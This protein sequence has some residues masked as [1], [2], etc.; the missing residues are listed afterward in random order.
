MEGL[1]PLQPPE[2][3]DIVPVFQYYLRSPFC[4]PMKVVLDGGI[5]GVGAAIS[6]GATAWLAHVIVAEERR[7][8]GIGGFIV[9]RL[10]ELLRAAGC[11]TVSLI[12]TDLGRPVYRRAGF[13]DQADYL[14]FT[15]REPLRLAGIS[16]HIARPLPGEIDAVLALDQ[17]I[18]GEDRRAVLADQLEGSYVYRRGGGIAGYY[19]PEFY[20]GPVIAD[21]PEAGIELMKLRYAWA[22]KGVLPAENR[23]GIDF[24]ESRGFKKTLR[25]TRM[26][27]GRGFPWRPQ[28][29]FGRISGN[30][31]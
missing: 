28:G 29:L 21:D 11:D 30:L 23:E 7:G 3:P 18:S 9:G 4:T 19:L 31:G 20:E 24:L 13:V 17:R 27:L 14:L 25:L 8:Q 26:V 1:R 15:G 16:G 2:W 12:A 22:C 5:A 10:L 6:L